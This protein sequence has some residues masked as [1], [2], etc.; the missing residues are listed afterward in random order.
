MTTATSTYVP[1]TLTTDN[2]DE[3]TLLDLNRLLAQLNPENPEQ[4]TREDLIHALC[5]S[6]KIVVVRYGPTIIGMGVVARVPRLKISEVMFHEIVV[7]EKH[8]GTRAAKLLID[9]MNLEAR[10]TF[11]A[12]RIS[13]TSSPKRVAAHKFYEKHG[14]QKVDTTVFR[15]ERK[16]Y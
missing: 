7:D 15:G 12:E 14:F 6:Q 13:F 11:F 10:I 5:Q 8:R 1:G 16:L 3:Q 2:K 4:L 9:R